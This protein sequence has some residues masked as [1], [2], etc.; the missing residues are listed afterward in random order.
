MK[1]AGIL[2]FGGAV[3]PLDLPA[4][5][6]PETDEVLLAVRAAGVGNWDEFVRTGGWDTGIRPP[7]ALGVEAAG[8]VTAVGGSVRGIEV[9]AL[10]TTHSLP[11]RDQGSWA[12][13]FIA[14][15]AH[16][17]V[18]PRG[19]AADVAGA[20]AIPALTADQ[21]LTD[22]LH[23]QAGQTVLVHGAGGVTGGVLVQLAV[24]YGA[25][26]IATASPASEDRVRAFGAQ[27]VVD[28]RQ[29]GWPGQVRE[30]TGGVDAA[31][32]AA[33]EGAAEAVAAVRDGG[34]L[35]TIT[36]DPP[37]TGRGIA[38]TAVQVIPNGPR[39]AHLLT[40]FASGALTIDIAAA[41]PLEDAAAAL[42]LARQGMHG[43]AV[44]LCPAAAG[45]WSG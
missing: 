25:R 8:V 41:R 14:A 24:A 36:G 12:E 6:S 23:V 11:L 10:V 37:H 20:A 29:P 3:E 19:V 4:P 39:L 32:N 5:R 33:R 16:V 40:L 44:V 9:G 18:V 26:V 13:G 43:A 42:T 38:L 28:Y 35:A 27:T 2:Q 15:A 31:V 34:R 45:G 21:A 7:M 22:A 17:A 30:L 1:A